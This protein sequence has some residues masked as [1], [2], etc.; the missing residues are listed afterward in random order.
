M[1]EVL[2]MELNQEAKDIIIKLSDTQVKEATRQMEL[3]I[4]QANDLIVT[5]QRESRITTNSFSNLISNLVRVQAD[6]A[7]QEG[8][9]HGSEYFNQMKE[10]TF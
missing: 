8:I 9:V 6:F 7:K 5:F 1:K 4:K 3:S 10:C 2:N